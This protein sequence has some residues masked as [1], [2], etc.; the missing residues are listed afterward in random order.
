M[1]ACT[2]LFLDRVAS[3]VIPF[4]QMNNALTSLASLSIG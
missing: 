3:E 2:E 1:N 4:V